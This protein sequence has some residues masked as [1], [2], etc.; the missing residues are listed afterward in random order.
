M[1]GKDEKNSD[2]KKEGK[3]GKRVIIHT[4]NK[5]KVE[6]KKNKRG[7]VKAKSDSEESENDRKESENNRKK[8]L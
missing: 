7:R 5:K 6:F 4:V 1:V 3:R 2:I 8:K